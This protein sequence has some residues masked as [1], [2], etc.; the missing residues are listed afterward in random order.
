MGALLD[1]G[2]AMNANQRKVSIVTA[3]AV[4]FLLAQY[5]SYPERLR[6]LHNEWL[7][8]AI[9]AAAIGASAFAWMGGKR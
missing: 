5:F 7:S 8:L 3:I 6:P 1:R 9:L 2:C 4:G